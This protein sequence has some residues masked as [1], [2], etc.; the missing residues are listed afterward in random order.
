MIVV[1]QDTRPSRFHRPRA[2]CCIPN[3][4]IFRLRYS[5]AVAALSVDR[6]T[7]ADPQSRLIPK[8][9]DLLVNT[10]RLFQFGRRSA[11]AILVSGS[12][13]LP[14]RAVGQRVV[15]G[16]QSS[17][18]PN[19]TSIGVRDPLVYTKTPVLPGFTTRAL[20]V[21]YQTL[22]F[23]GSGIRRLLLPR[24]LIGQRRPTPNH[25]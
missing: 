9:Q 21:V 14:L 17:V 7:T 15:V 1:Y 16:Q 8:T 23:S 10:S 4:A 11:R 19:E 20:V 13:I 25:Y 22:R 18:F 24:R 3:T 2:G 6:S 5:P 12:A